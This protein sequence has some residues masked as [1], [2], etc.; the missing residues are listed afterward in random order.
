MSDSLMHRR[1]FVRLS[2]VT[3]VAAAATGLTAGGV[4]VLTP[5]TVNPLQAVGFAEPPTGGTLRVVDAST[6]SAGDSVLSRSGMHVTVHGLRRSTQASSDRLV[7]FNAIFPSGRGTVPFL[8]W[9][10]PGTS[11]ARGKFLVPPSDRLTFS[12]DLRRK[13]S[14]AGIP[15]VDVDRYL[16]YTS[17]SA[18]EIPKVELSDEGKG[19]CVLV[20]TGTG[21]KLRRGTYFLALRNATGADRRIDWP[22]MAVDPQTLTLVRS[23][24]AVDLDY[25]VVTVDRA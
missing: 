4:G 6:L 20:L 12:V 18:G 7:H 5:K 17:A 8:A 13:N 10:E 3:L 21:P 25:L 2:S 1:E 11:S 16:G 19:L 22:S 24:Q 9:S 23:G 15:S 14:L